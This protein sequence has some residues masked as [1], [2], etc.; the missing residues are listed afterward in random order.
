M[1]DF[2]SLQ[3]LIDI[4]KLLEHY[5]FEIHEDDGIYMRSACKIHNGDN[6]TAFVVNR[7]TSLWYCHTGCGGGDVFTLVQ[8]M[9]DCTFVEAVNFLVDKFDLDVEQI[10]IDALEAEVRKELQEWMAHNKAL[11]AE[12][13]FEECPIYPETFDIASYR[14]FDKATLDAFGVKFIKEIS[15]INK[16]GKYYTIHDRMFFPIMFED[17]YIGFSLRKTKADDIMK[18][19]HQPRDLNVGRVLYNFDAVA[20]A[21]EI[22]VVEGIIDVL[23]CYEANIPAVCTF[24]AHM[25]REQE[26]LLLTT[27]A[28][29]T[30]AY[31]GDTAGREATRKAIRRLRN[32]AT[33]RMVEFPDG[34]DCQSI[35]RSQLIDLYNNRKKI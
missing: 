10:E 26:K 13:P 19:S 32:K 34:E 25:S 33:I 2:K 17:K 11:R 23:A 22:V 21:E 6:P 24:G 20:D 9:E 1:K 18:W 16:K 12:A 3:S 5:G 15:L 29:I 8:K 4:D 30:F 35:K 14:D 7:E 28:D 27:G 31:D